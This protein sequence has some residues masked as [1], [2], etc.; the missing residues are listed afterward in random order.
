M[1][2]RHAIMPAAG[3]VIGGKSPSL[4]CEIILIYM[5]LRLLFNGRCT[6]GV[7]ETIRTNNIIVLRGS[8]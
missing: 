8:H 6:K 7:S 3:I 2:W 5:A 1:Q 4:H